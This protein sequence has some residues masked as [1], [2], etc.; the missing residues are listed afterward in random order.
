MH[1]GVKEVTEKGGRRFRRQN[2]AWS[3]RRGI[4]QWVRAGSLGS[5]SPSVGARGLQGHSGESTSVST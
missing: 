1:D 4:R 2:E 5:V 3:V